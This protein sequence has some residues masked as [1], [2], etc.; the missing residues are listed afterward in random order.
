MFFMQQLGGSIFLAVSQNIFSSR[1][2]D[3]LSGIAGLDTEAGCDRSS[4]H[5]AVGSAQNCHSHIQ[6]RASLY[7]SRFLG[8]GVEEDQEKE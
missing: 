8:R 5:C 2:V 7:D 1:P 6:P 3:S 4:Y